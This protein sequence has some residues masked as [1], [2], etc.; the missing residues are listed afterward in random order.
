M[1]MMKRIKKFGINILITVIGFV[2]FTVSAI[3]VPL[4]IIWVG[5]LLALSLLYDIRSN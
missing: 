3:I 4:F 2:F 5:L 1:K